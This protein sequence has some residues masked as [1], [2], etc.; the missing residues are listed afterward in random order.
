MSA[1]VGRVTDAQLLHGPELVDEL[2]VDAS[3]TSS[4]SAEVQTWPVSRS[5]RSCPSTARRVGVEDDEGA[6][7]AQLEQCGFSGALVAIFSPW[8]SSR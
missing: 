3:W 5:S 4:R 8:R 6:V 2:V 7:A 1:L